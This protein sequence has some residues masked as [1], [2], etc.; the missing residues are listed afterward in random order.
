MNRGLAVVASVAVAA[1]LLGAVGVASAATI[2]RSTAKSEARKAASRTAARA[3][4]SI[5]PRSFRAYC[6]TEGER[7]RARSWGCR[8][9]SSNGQC[10]GTVNVYVAR[11]G[12]VRTRFNRIACAD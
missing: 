1:V 8:V 6:G 12:R 11:G 2:S 4:I 7:T 3:G 5:P 9:R 10:R